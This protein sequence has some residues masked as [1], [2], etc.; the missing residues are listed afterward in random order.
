MPI[1]VASRRTQ[2]KTLEATFESPV[3]LDVTSNGSLG[4]GVMTT[5]SAQ[6]P[7]PR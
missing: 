2:K 1:H 3:I 6:R 7:S 5:G 4:E